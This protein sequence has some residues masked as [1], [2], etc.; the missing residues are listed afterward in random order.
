MNAATIRVEDIAASPG[1]RHLHTLAGVSHDLRYASSNNFAGRRLYGRLDCAW[2]RTE[3]ASGLEA[4]ARWL[5]HTRPGWRLLVLDALRPQRVQEAIW[6]DVAGTPM[7]EYFAN[8]E[9]GSIHS[10][11]MAVDV[12]LLA[13]DGSEADMGS[14]FDEM[15]ERSHPALHER[16]LAQG[17]LT[18]A[19]VGQRACLAAAMAAGGFA[20][21]PHEW[22][23]FD[24]GD[25]DRVRREL[26]RVL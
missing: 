14:G 1:F 15:T 17:V 7:Q 23:H 2:L 22:W 26:P 16:L 11:G 12:T 18:P 21:I 13:P 3:A 19:Q 10:Y 8:P 5:Q 4:A 24:H 6:V 20:G 25:R 9:R